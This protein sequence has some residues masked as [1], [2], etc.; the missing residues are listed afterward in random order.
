MNL[1]DLF[2]KNKA[3]AILIVLAGIWLLMRHTITESLRQGYATCWLYP[4]SWPSLLG[5]TATS[6]A[7]WIGLLAAILFALPFGRTGLLATLVG[8]H[9]AQ[10]VF[11]LFGAISIFIISS[12]VSIVLV[13]AIVEYSLRHPKAAWIHIRLKPVQSIFAPSIRKNSILWLA[14]GNLVGS[15]WH[16]SALGIICDVPRPRIWLGLL[17]GNLV[18]FVL[19]YFFSKVPNLDTISI[20][21]LILTLVMALSSPAL[22]INWKKAKRH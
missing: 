8:I 9:L 20:M 2:R 3:T 5:I 11:G 12:I 14:I 18:G 4:D 6:P 19:V 1:L 13:H 17:L 16:M 22:W 10:P 7:I 15:Q 21:L